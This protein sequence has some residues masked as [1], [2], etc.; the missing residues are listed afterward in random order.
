VQ[1]TLVSIRFVSIHFVSIRF[2][3]IRFVSIRFVSIR[4]VSIRFVSIRFVSI[5]FVKLPHQGV[6]QPWISLRSRIFHGANCTSLVLELRRSSSPEE[7]LS[8]GPFLQRHK[9]RLLQRS[10]TVETCWSNFRKACVF[11]MWLVSCDKFAHR[12]ILLLREI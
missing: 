8:G 12:K 6:L 7:L 1:Y 3:S 5:R 9:V 11:P 10:S 2:V 4:F